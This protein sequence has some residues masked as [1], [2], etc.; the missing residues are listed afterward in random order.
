MIDCI[1]TN[2]PEYV[3]KGKVV[4]C[5]INDREVAFINR[6]MTTPKIKKDPKT[7]DIGK[8]ESFYS[9]ASSLRELKSINFDAIKM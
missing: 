8:F 9:V 5:G 6:S 4:A 1:A 7:I 3:P 2:K